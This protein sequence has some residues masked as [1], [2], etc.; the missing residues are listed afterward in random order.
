M[1]KGICRSLRT[2]GRLGAA[3]CLFLMAGAALS[4]CQ[5]VF[6]TSL[7]SP[8]ARQD[9]LPA[10]ISLSE[11][12]AYSEIA[13]DSN[14]AQ[15]AEELLGSLLA[16]L[17]SGALSTEEYAQA[18]GA[19]GELAVLSTGI[20]GALTSIVTLVPTDGSTMGPELE[21]Q[22]NKII[23]EQVS[24]D[25][26][27]VQAIMLMAE[28]DA[29]YAEPLDYILAGAALLYD[30]TGSEVSGYV[31]EAGSEDETQYNT[32]KELMQEGFELAS[33]DQGD[34]PVMQLLALVIPQGE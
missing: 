7:A 32:A 22:V 3:T 33:E 20:S 1:A 12:L 27:A 28:G 16:S 25:D 15:L 30:L 8:L 9:V 19:A 31:P 18:L 17:D 23:D 2:I 13:L 6:T 4:S 14:D 26:Q 21:E 34:S 24:V 10:S 5:E 29:E 11:A